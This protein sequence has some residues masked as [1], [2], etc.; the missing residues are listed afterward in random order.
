MSSA[1]AETT[2]AAAGTESAASTEPTDATEVTSADS[3][4]SAPAEGEP[5]KIGWSNVD[6]G[7]SA[8]PGYTEGARIAVEYINNELGG[9]DGRPLELVTCSQI[10]DEASATQCGQEF[11]NDDSLVALV[12]GLL[13]FGGQFYGATSSQ[14]RVVIGTV[15]LTEG[16]YGATGVRFWGSGSVGQLGAEAIFAAENLGAKKIGI[17]YRDEPAGQAGA[18]LVKGILAN[19]EAEVVAV[20]VA[21]GASDYAPALTAAGDVDA[22]ILVTDTTGCIGVAN[23]LEQ[24]GQDP[25]IVG[26]ASCQDPSGLEAV[27]DKME[28]WYFGEA[29]PTPLLGEG[30]N[31]DVDA[32]LQAIDTYGNGTLESPVDDFAYWAF[33]YVLAIRSLMEEIGVDNLSPETFDAAIDTFGGPVPL[34]ATNISCPGKTQPNVCTSDGW[35]FQ[36]QDSKAVTVMDE[37]IVVDDFTGS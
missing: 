25:E 28:G 32:Y 6:E 7:P 37:P 34:G 14:G 10:G 19:T 33:G 5:I 16:D 2:D 8:F 3:G 18:D 9:V 23:A 11:A 22:L 29:G 13:F 31:D 17:V 12:T 26:S 21:M 24:L 1:A 27:G 35:I 15:P 4:A 30:V 36:F 20:P